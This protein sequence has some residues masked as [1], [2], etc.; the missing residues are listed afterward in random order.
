MT[1]EQIAKRFYELA[2]EG[3]WDVVLDELFSKEAKSIEPSHAQGLKSVTG[4]NAIREKAKQWAES[5]E[6]V[7]GGYTNEPI[8]AG[9]YF[10]CAMGIDMTFK[11]KARKK[12]DEIAL[13]EVK[14]GRIISEQFFY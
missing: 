1:T 5:I 14:D 6:E 12:I 3:K 9:N 13:Y 2:R 11:G 4:L 7:H 10:A 8:V